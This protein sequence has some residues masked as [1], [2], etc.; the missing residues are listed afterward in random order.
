M[1]FNRNVILTGLTSFFTDVSSE[2][3]YPL[4]QAFVST[5]LA[6]QKAL[7]GPALGIIEGVAESTASLLKDLP[8][9]YSDKVLTL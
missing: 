5:V 6:S 7:V 8:G 2:M 9:Y 1:K 4:I 3:L